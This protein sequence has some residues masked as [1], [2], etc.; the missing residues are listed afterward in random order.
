[1]NVD[2]KSKQ[3]YRAIIQFA[4]IFSFCHSSIFSISRPPILISP[5]DLVEKEINFSNLS[6]TQK[7]KQPKIPASWGGNS[8]AQET[9]KVD[10]I[11]LTVYSLS[12]GAWILHKKVKLS[13]STIEI[14]GEEAYK[15][16]LKGQTKVEDPENGITLTAG[17]GIYDKSAETVILEGRPTL[18]FK[19]KENKIT[20][21]TAPYLKRYLSDNKT[22][23]E[24]GAIVENGEYTIYS[25]TA[26]FLEKEES[27][28]MENYPFIFGKDTFLT[29]EKVTYSNATKNTV[30]E[31]D[32]ILLKLG[33][34]NPRKKASLKKDSKE[35]EANSN[36]PE[37]LET[38]TLE[39]VK[40]ISIFTGEKMIYQ[41]GDDASRYVGMFGTAK[42][43]RDDFEFTGSYIKAFGKEN[44]NI[45]AKDEVVLL[46]KENHV[47]LSGNIL[48]HSKE[49][50]YTHITDNA[51]IEFLD[52]ENTEVN[53]TM[54]SVEIE[55]FGEKKEIVSRGE[56]NLVSNESTVHGEY[57]TYFEEN[58]KMFVDGNPSL[59]QENKTVYCGRI[60]IYPNA[61]KI[62]L[63]DGLNVNKK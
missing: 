13:A 31:N 6:D 3:R 28:L 16:F 27:L 39:K 19:D 15:G 1:M 14:I 2:I 49:K 11:D 45:E 25:E 21:I 9:K 62:I 57:A 54:T 37:S 4:L 29:G 36:N 17:K 52:K 61:D 48:E 60:I 18:Y 35:V 41:T 26:I 55:R 43:I 20:K 53:S 8:L 63:T 56:V 51:M 38:D 33:Y 22:V 24:G 7:K 50:N 42:M 47:R 32:T 44:G 23:F 5:L 10:G 40:R 30:L 34:E 59:K 12:G 46:D 58:E